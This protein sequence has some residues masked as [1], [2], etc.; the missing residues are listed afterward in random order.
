MITMYGEHVRIRREGSP[1]SVPY[2]ILV[3]VLNGAEWTLFKGINSL[4]DD[5]AFTNARA[6]ANRAFT[7]GVQ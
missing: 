5:Y 3:E 6:A 4:S 7:Q 2:D 1:F